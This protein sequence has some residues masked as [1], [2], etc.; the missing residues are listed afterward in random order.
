MKFLLKIKKLLQRR[1]Y[2]ALTPPRPM[3]YTD[4][5]RLLHSVIH[6]YQTSRRLTTNDFSF[7][8]FDHFSKLFGHNNQSTLRKMCEPRESRRGAK[9]GFEEAILIIR[10][11]KDYRLFEFFRHRIE[12]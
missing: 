9:L 10:E 1:P 12:Q 8:A 11:T 5:H 3:Y 6:N 2:D 4:L 7:D